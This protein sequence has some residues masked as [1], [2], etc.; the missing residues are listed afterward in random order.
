MKLV[1]LSS[2]SL[3]ALLQYIMMMGRK[4]CSERLKPLGWPLVE[5]ASVQISARFSIPLPVLP[6]TRMLLDV[7]D[8][9]NM[10]LKEARRILPSSWNQ[11]FLNCRKSTRRRSSLILS[12][13]TA[14]EMFKTL[15]SCLLFTYSELALGIG[16]VVELVVSLV[17]DKVM[18]LRPMSELWHIAKWVS[19]CIASLFLHKSTH[20]LSLSFADS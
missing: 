2:S 16:P 17:F 13:M 7:F 20:F 9:S 15:Q 1:V 12:L 18:R 10:L 3:I 11:C 4:S 8:C 6:P 19:V 5:T 14:L